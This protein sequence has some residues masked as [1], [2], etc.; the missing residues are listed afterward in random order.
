MERSLAN[1]REAQQKALATV[2]ALEE[3]IEQLSCPSPGI[4]QNY[5]CNQRVGTAGHI[6]PEDGSKGT[7][8]CNLKTALPPTSNTTPPEETQ[9]L[10]ERWWLPRT[11]IW[12][13]CQ[14]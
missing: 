11:P 12:R 3:E 7:T 9:S 14:N 13:S 10:T 6:D 1:A 2:A 5:G 8:R 4:C